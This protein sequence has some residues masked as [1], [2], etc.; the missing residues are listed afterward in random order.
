MKFLNEIYW[1][2]PFMVSLSVAAATVAA[3]SIVADRRRQNRKRADDVGFMPW[4]AITVF[5]MLM[6]V[7]T[8]AISLKGR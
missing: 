6:A 1:N 3:I 7:M 4:S 5:S 8:L 2:D